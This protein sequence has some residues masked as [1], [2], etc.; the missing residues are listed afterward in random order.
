[1]FILYWEG[2]PGKRLPLCRHEDGTHHWDDTDRPEGL[3]EFPSVL[4]A[5]EYLRVMRLQGRL[6]CDPVA[7]MVR[8]S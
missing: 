7:V 4:H 2:L 1:M 8:P 6:R 3:L 5:E